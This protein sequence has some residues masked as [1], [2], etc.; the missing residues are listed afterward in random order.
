MT[1]PLA[2]R[3][4]TVGKVVAVEGAGALV[5]QNASEVVGAAARAWGR[6]EHRREVQG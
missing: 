2:N 1:E 6:E 4:L 5:H 3:G